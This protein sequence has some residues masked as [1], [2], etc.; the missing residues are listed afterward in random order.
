MI[1]VRDTTCRGRACMSIKTDSAT[2]W[3]T[4]HFAFLGKNNLPLLQIAA[5]VR[6]KLE[7]LY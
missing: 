1:P 5:K 2:S 3:C 6:R 7:L 4:G